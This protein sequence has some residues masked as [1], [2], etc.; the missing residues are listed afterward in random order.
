M[1]LTILQLPQDVLLELAKHLNVGD[2]LSFL[3]TCRAIR[4]LRLERSL[5]LE[6]LIRIREV[7]LQPLPLSTAETLDT[8]SRDELQK[9]VHRAHGLKNNWES[10]KPRI[11]GMHSLSVTSQSEIFCIPGAHIVVTHGWGSMSC[12]DILTSQRVGDLEFP[13]LIVHAEALSME[14]NGKSLIGACFQ[15]HGLIKNLVVICVDF[16]D[17]AHIS[18]SYVVSPAAKDTLQFPSGFFID[19]QIMGFLADSKLVTWRLDADAAIQTTPYHGV[20]TGAQC[21]PIGRSI[22]ALSR[23]SARSEGKLQVIPHPATDRQ[24]TVISVSPSPCEIYESIKVPYPAHWRT[25]TL[26]DPYVFAPQY[27]IFAVI[28]R[29]FSS[30]QDEELAF[31]HFRPARMVHGE[32]EFSQSCVYRH[33]EAISDVAVGVSGTYVLLRINPANATP[34]L[35]LVHFNATPVPHT[36]FRRLEVEDTLVFS[37]VQIAFD[38][39]QGLVLLVDN[40]GE[41]TVLSYA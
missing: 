8:L 3:S 20:L 29:S 39:Q 16:R 4:E 14:M 33:G 31:I 37:C 34:Y 24:S 12:W 38:E 27:G 30:V 25:W 7:E 35:G 5:W 26:W 36:T 2:L 6:T 28:C 23:G 13:E 19:P 40:V 11:I 41:M 22:Y 1:S 15:L 17:R 9:V 18:M 10:E 21:L 32:L